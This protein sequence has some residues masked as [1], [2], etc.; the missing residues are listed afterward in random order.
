MIGTNDQ[1]GRS[2]VNSSS[3]SSP[4]GVGRG[5]RRSIGGGGG[6]EGGRGIT[7]LFRCLWQ[8]AVTL[9]S[10]MKDSHGA[11]YT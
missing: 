2:L 5:Q 7:Q 1:F 6:G 3:S 10:L 9:S 4:V 11:C 8:T